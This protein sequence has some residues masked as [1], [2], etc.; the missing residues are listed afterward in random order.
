MAE[1]KNLGADVGT[2]GDWLYRQGEL[3]LGPIPVQQIVE[4]LYAGELDGRTEVAPVGQRAFRRVADVEGFRLHLAKAEAKLRVE[5][6][7]RAERER[8]RRQRNVRI[9]AVVVV[10][11][12]VAGG[13]AAAARYLA[14]HNPLKRSDGMATSEISFEAPRIAVARARGTDEEL[15]DYPGGGISTARK[16]G[17]ERV[18]RRGGAGRMNSAAEEPD[19]LQTASFDREALKAVIASKRSTL[20]PCFNEEAQR[21]PGF[22]AKIPLEFVIGNDGRVSKLWVDH[23]SYKQGPLADCLLRELRRWP[24]K[25][26]PGEQATVSLSFTIGKG[27]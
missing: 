2:G 14:I 18:S 6:A 21:H 11:I 7:A 26:Y 25:P 9:T 1:S 5:A 22:S 13:A 3:V 8:E 15:L 10:A 23:P 12:G 24:F 20:Y 16:P 19:G 27:G 4:K 17:G